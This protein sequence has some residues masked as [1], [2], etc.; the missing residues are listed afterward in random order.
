MSNNR[1]RNYQDIQPTPI[2]SNEAPVPILRWTSNFIENNFN[3][4]KNKLE[5]YSLEHFGQL[6][7]LFINEKYYI[8]PKIP[9]IRRIQEKNLELKTN[10]EIKMRQREIQIQTLENDKLKLYALMYRKLSEESKSAIITEP[11]WETVRE[12]AD[13]LGLWKLIKR[14]HMGGG[15]ETR[16]L[17]YSNLNAIKQYESE[18]LSL[19][20]ERF[21]TALNTFKTVDQTPPDDDEA[22]AIFIHNLSDRRFSSFKIHLKN[23]TAFGNSTSPKTIHDALVKAQKWEAIHP[24][25]ITSS[26]IVSTKDSLEIAKNQESR[27]MQN[28]LKWL[29]HYQLEWKLKERRIIK[30]YSTTNVRYIYL[31][32]ITF[33]LTFIRP[34]I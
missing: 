12:N 1:K 21:R 33:F 16:R 7:K 24:N 6:G 29:M 23:E 19:Y 14:T 31:L 5:N 17:L 30:F 2:T 26:S 34:I 3:D 4:F 18:Q 9:P 32:M 15:G 11:E 22:T 20:L 25:V 28:T 8:P 10:Y 13:A 27:R